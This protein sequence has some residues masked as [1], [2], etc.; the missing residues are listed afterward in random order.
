MIRISYWQFRL[1]LGIALGGLAVVA[2]IA[3][4]TGP[5]IAHL[6]D[7]TVATCASNGG[8][9]STALSLFNAHDQVLK[10]IAQ[11]I[12]LGL[13]AV[14]GMFWGAPLVARELESGTFRLAWTQG[15]SRLRW[16][17]AK[18]A[19]VGLAALTVQG[20]IGLALAW[21]WN[22]V[23]RANHNRFSPALFGAFG[24]APVGY[25]AF[26]LAL[27]ITAGVVI[28]RTLPA[29][30]TTLAV[31]AG[32]RLA[33]TYWVR[34]YFAA[35]TRLV[36]PISP[37]QSIGIDSPARGQMSLNFFPPGLPDAWLLSS[38]VTNAAG[39]KPSGAVLSQQCPQLLQAQIGQGN[40]SAALTACV[41]KLSATFHQTVA[42]QPASRYWPFQWAELGLF[43][44][45]ALALAAFSAWWI[46][47]RL[48]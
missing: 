29:M 23:G 43:T 31:F 13:P 30:A 15:R 39:Q 45:L 22:P 41:T 4:L 37:H 20:L 33:V 14:L 25:A 44:A 1:P 42:Y 9:C 35:P 47:R 18:L 26:A 12:P 24:V 28:R 46:R 3:A 19:V 8:D 34:P 36:L 38:Q 5:G 7:T 16:L 2:V 11:L 27:G 6:Y 10:V 17:G 40:M 21:W 32:V 48:A